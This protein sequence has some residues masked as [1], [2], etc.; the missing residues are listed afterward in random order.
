MHL[1][2]EPNRSARLLLI[3]WRLLRCNP[4][5]HRRTAD[6]VGRRHRRLRPNTLPTLFSIVA[7]S[8]FMVVTIAGIAEAVGVNNGCTAQ[9]NGQDPAQL[10]SDHPLVVHKGGVVQFVGTVPPDVQNAPK[11]QLISNTHIDVDIVSGLFGV[12]S[13]DHPG[14]GPI[15]GGN[16]SVDKYLKYGVGL[17][18]VTG[19]ATGGPGS[20]SCDGD[21]YVQLKDGNPLGKPIGAAAAALAVV[22]VAGAGLSTL[23]GDPPE[24]ALYGRGLAHDTETGLVASLGCL[25]FL[26]LATGAAVLGKDIAATS[27]AATASVGGRPR[28][29]WAH[30]HPIM[31]FISGLLLGVGITVLLQQFAVWPLTIVTAIGFPIV[32]A[33]ICSLR[34]WLG[35]A[36]RFAAQM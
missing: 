12:T 36:Y 15:W 27:V 11:D 26:V 14:H 1:H 9:L 2:H 3:A 10:D 6:P 16:Q 35:K 34:A 31:G 33:V 19:E 29:V 25:I 21:A 32:T 30:G 18:H 28:R 17:Y 24:D 20:W 13:S 8:G 7:L 5:M 23:G 4:F 22:G